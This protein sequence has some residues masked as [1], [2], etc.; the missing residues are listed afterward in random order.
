M[1]SLG[2]RRVSVQP[3]GEQDDLRQSGP[4]GRH[5]QLPTAQRP[6]RPAERLVSQ[7]ELSH[8]SCQ[9]NHPP[10]RKRGDDP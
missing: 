7:T 4:P 2:V 3:G 10:Y 1:C 5:H 8:V 6:Q 9:Q